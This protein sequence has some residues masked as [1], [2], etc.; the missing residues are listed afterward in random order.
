MA[1]NIP[2][3]R[4]I[5]QAHKEGKEGKHRLTHNVIHKCQNYYKCGI[6]FFK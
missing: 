4:N 1:A 3:I 2:Y 6:F 5:T